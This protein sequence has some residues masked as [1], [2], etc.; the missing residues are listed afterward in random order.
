M[1]HTETTIN[2]ARLAALEKKSQPALLNEVQAAE[3]LGIGRRKFHDVR[4]EPWFVAHCTALEL[5]PR[6]LRFHRDELLAAAMNAP[7][8]VV[9]SEPVHLASARADRSAA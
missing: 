9:Q 3:L 4:Q 5:S 6:C 8:R 1:H 7:R 2:P